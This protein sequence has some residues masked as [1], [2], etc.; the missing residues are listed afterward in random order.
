MGDEEH[1]AGKGVESLF[2]LLDRF[3]VLKAVMKGPVVPEA[4]QAVVTGMMQDATFAKYLDKVRVA[5]ALAE[6]PAGILHE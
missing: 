3:D 6:V 5:G 2:E 4:D 1:R